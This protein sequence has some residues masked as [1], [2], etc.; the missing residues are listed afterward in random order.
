[1]YVYSLISHRVQQTSQFYIPGIGT[2]SCTV[3]FPLGRIQR[4]FCSYCHS[5]FSIVRS[6]RYPSLLGG[7]RR[8][9]MKGLP[10]TSTHGPIIPKSFNYLL[11]K[12]GYGFG[13]VGLSVCLCVCSSV[14]NI[15]QKVMKGL[16]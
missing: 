10:N 2:L 7:Q 6:T 13:S 16:E 9:D 3:S 8:H 1:M 5:Q 4:I 15:T 14:N 12:E 11:G